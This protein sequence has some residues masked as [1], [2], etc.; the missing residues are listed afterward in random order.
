MRQS[1]RESE[2]ER[3]LLARESVRQKFTFHQDGTVASTNIDE[4]GWFQWTAWKD[5]VSGEIHRIRMGLGTFVMIYKA[6]AIRHNPF[7]GGGDIAVYEIMELGLTLVGH[8]ATRD[9]EARIRSAI[10]SLYG[11][12]LQWETLTD[13][14]L[15]YSYIV[16]K[17]RK[18]THRIVAINASMMLGREIKPDAWRKRVTTWAED[19]GLPKIE[20][21]KRQAQM[22]GN[23]LSTG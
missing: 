13:F 4:D 17:N 8:T 23:E 11:A 6:M 19:A 18:A 2:R 10:I 9:D 3:K 1:R 22:T 12:A 5:E 16:L 20:Q 21:R 14:L 7:M 15:E